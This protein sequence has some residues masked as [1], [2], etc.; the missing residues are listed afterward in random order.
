M[1]FYLMLTFGLLSF[2]C[3]HNSAPPQQSNS[4]EIKETT[5]DPKPAVA[6]PS[7][8]EAA[9]LI[10]W[11]TCHRKNELRR[12][13]IYLKEKGCGLR[14]YKFGRV[15]EIASA[16]AGAYFCKE[17]LRMVRKNLESAGFICEQ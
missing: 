17:K 12:L 11:A 16:R 3:S 9:H 7:E 8:Q 10:Q 2:G 6:S 14:Y 15:D 5:V 1:R 4:A 13:E